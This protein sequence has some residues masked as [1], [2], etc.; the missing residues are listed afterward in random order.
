MEP[1]EWQGESDEG[2]APSI[3]GMVQFRQLELLVES[4]D[5]ADLRRLCLLLGRQA[6]VTQPAA[7][8]WAVGQAA[9]AGPRASADGSHEGW[10]LLR[11]IQV[12][13]QAAP[14]TEQP[15]PA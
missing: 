2:M 11:A 9:A 4:L 6:L 5:S 8:R 1:G 7:L 12:D 15:E 3:S 14:E 10:R 13:A